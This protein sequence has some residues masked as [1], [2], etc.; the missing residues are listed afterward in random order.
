ML[1]GSDFHTNDSAEEL[2]HAPTIGHLCKHRPV[3][4]SIHIDKLQSEPCWFAGI[5]ISSESLSSHKPDLP[6]ARGQAGR[7]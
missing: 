6:G 5:H 3:L 4:E 7:A 2:E 1:T